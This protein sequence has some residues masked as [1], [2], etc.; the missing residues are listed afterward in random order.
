MAH[1][2][3]PGLNWRGAQA[4]LDAI[5]RNQGLAS[6]RPYYLEVRSEIARAE[7]VRR[8]RQRALDL[9][10]EARE[11]PLLSFVRAQRF[12]DGLACAAKAFELTHPHAVIGVTR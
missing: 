6:A 3:G 7:A 2:P 11:L 5:D 8:L 4:V 10:A 1:R 9:Y 12:G